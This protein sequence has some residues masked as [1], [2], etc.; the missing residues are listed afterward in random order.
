MRILHERLGEGDRAGV[1][2]AQHAIGSLDRQHKQ[3]VQM[4]TFRDHLDAFRKAQ[5]SG[6]G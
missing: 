1:E 2:W 6:W 3:A 4:G 5:P